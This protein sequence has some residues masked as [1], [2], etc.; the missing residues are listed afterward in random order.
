MRYDAKKDSTYSRCAKSERESSSSNEE[1]QEIVDQK[2]N[3]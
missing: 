1:G 2:S 3:N